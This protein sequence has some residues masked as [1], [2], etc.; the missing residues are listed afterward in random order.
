MGL[1]D[2]WSTK[3]SSIMVFLFYFL[4]FAI[5]IYCFCTYLSD[6][7]GFR[8]I[9]DFNTWSFGQIVA[10][11]VWT[12]PLCEY[13]HLELRESL[14]FPADCRLQSSLASC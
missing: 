11:I 13:L 7:Y 3:L 6:L 4:F 9:V 10:I 14:S 8:D 12:Q 5:Y 1:M 2:D